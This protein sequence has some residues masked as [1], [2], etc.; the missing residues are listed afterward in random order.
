MADEQST[1][2]VGEATTVDW[3]DWPIYLG[4]YTDYTQDDSADPS[5][6][7]WSLVKGYDGAQGPQGPTGA[8]GAK[9]DKGDTGFFIGSTPPPNPVVGTVWA[10]NDAYGNMVSAKTWNGSSWVS[11]AFTQDLVAGNIT[12]TKIVGGELDVNKITVKNAQNIP[13]E[14]TVSLGDKFSSI[15]EDA[16]GLKLTVTGGGNLL[17]NTTDTLQKVSVNGWTFYTTS[18]DEPVAKHQLDGQTVTLSA[19]IENPSKDAWVQMWTNTG[20]IVQGNKIPAGG[21]GWS[22]ITYTMPSEFTDWNLVTG[23]QTCALPICFPVT[24]TKIVGGELDV[25]KTTVKNAQNVPIEGTVSLG[26]KFSSIK[27][28]ADGLKL[29]VTGGGNLLNNTTDTLKNISVN[30]WTFYTTSTDEPVA[31]HQLDGQKVTLSAWIE[32][33]SKEAWVQMWTNTGGPFQG[34]HIPAGGSGWSQVTYTM[35]SGFTDWNIV[36]GSGNNVETTIS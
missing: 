2:S 9:G 34:N 8:T 31:K 5:V 25:N 3:P 35:P 21:K 17:N 23:V 30:G 15:K 20:G 14:G 16:D 4:H 10:T 22:Q 19:W 7:T 1:T 27:E 18:T 26:D 13:I 32:N 24:A 33:P 12:A 28:D 6:Y 36:I 29:T 11:T